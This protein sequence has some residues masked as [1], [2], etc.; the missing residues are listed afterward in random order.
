MG[1]SDDL[2]LVK[3]V[4]L[5]LPD[6][7]LVENKEGPKGFEPPSTLV[8]CG[9]DP[10][11]R[12]ESKAVLF[13]LPAPEG[14]LE[15]SMPATAGGRNGLVDGVGLDVFDVNDWAPTPFNVPTGEKRE[16]T[17]PALV[18]RAGLVRLPSGAETKS[19]NSS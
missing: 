19:G 15:E 11:R 6:D 10:A 3:V 4:A 7:Q 8:R 12:R 5:S 17:V 18:L 13:P 1:P 14:L 16:G 2:I 9:M